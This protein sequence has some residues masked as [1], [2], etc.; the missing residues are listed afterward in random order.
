ML[1]IKLSY[2][3]IN[4]NCNI[5]EEEAEKVFREGET[6]IREE[7][8]SEWT[9]TQL[10]RASFIPWEPGSSD[11]V[12]DVSSQSLTRRHSFSG[13]NLMSGVWDYGT[14]ILD[15][16]SNGSNEAVSRRRCKSNIFQNKHLI[17]YNILLH[18]CFC[19]KLSRAV[20]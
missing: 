2:S 6:Q 15:S 3:L 8:F 14:S 18:F 20:I 17:I 13:W 16:P 1:W 12:M 7:N 10:R 9:Y 19:R 4:D 11:F 5:R